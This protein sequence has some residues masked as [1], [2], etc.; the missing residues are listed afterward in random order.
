MGGYKL[1]Q[2]VKTTLFKSL[3][4]ISVRCSL[5]CVDV[6]HGITIKLLFYIV[7]LQLDNARNKSMLHSFTTLE[8]FVWRHIRC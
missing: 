6:P 7:A 4:L 1:I 8:Y 3:L 5:I 2:G